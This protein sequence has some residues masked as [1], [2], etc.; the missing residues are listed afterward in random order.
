MAEMRIYEDDQGNQFYFNEKTGRIIP[1]GATPQDDTGPSARDRAR[2]VAQ[3]LTFGGADE[4]EAFLRSGGDWIADKVTGNNAALRYDQHLADIR[5]ANESYSGANPGENLALQMVGSLPAGVGAAR[6]LLR[7]A[8]TAVANNPMARNT[9][10]GLISGLVGGTLAG[11]EGDVSRAEGA[12]VGGTLGAVA[13]A[14]LPPAVNAAGKAIGTVA[15]PLARP[16]MDRLTAPGTHAQ[17]KLIEDLSRMNMSFDDARRAVLEGGEDAMLLDIGPATRAKAQGLAKKMTTHS[18]I[19]DAVEGRH[20]GQQSRMLATLDESLGGGQGRFWDID[21][22]VADAQKAQAAPLY[23]AAYEA[24]IPHS[25]ELRNILGRKKVQQAWQAA[26]EIADTRGQPW[27]H[28]EEITDVM[29][30]TEGWDWIKRGLDQ[31]IDGEVDATTGKVS[32]KGRELIRLKNEMLGHLDAANPA[33]KRARDNYAGHQSIRDAMRQG[34]RIFRDDWEL[35]R[36]YIAKLS[37]SEKEAFRV[38]VAR[39]IMDEIES[40]PETGNAA[41]RNKLRAEKYRKRM[42]EAFPDDESFK[43]FTDRVDKEWKWG[44]TRNRA[45]N[46]SETAMSQEAVKDLGI[47]KTEDL[48]APSRQGPVSWAWNLI[49]NTEPSAEEL[50]QLAEYLTTRGVAPSLGVIDTLESASRGPAWYPNV[51]PGMVPMSLISILSGNAGML[52]TDH[53]ITGNILP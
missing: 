26:Q 45:V 48:L 34:R 6:T 5:A 44:D 11:G 32:A 38:G 35:S 39:E 41:F 18:T 42:R 19:K 16:V 24:P 28:G 25:D 51:T 9:T 4:L 27:P 14:V 36:D 53:P 15:G 30:S 2:A 31:M 47:R 43:A 40:A 17:R 50:N 8:P 37:D 23:Q 13:G 33:Y 10:E 22:I 1:V 12:A 29:P 46:N 20:Q 49:R 52:G 7:H 21:Q 3:G